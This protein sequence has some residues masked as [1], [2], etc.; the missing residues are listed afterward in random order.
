MYLNIT[1]IIGNTPLIKMDL[2]GLDKINFYAKLEYY[3][4][5]GSVKD[6]AADYILKKLVNDSIIDQD[7]TIIESSSGNF[8]ISL[9]VFCKMHNLKFYC[10][11][12][13]NI[14]SVNEMLISSLSTRI[15]KVTEPDCYG[16]YLCNRLLKV[17]EL[18]NTIP[19]TY[20]INQYGNPYNAEAYYKT[21]GSELCN[22]VNNIDYIFVGVSSG[23]TIT[24]VSH[25]IKERFPKAKVIAVDSIGS[26]IFGQQPKKRNIPGIGSSIRP[27]IIKS[28]LIDDV[29]FIDEKEAVEMCHMLL[30]RHSIFVG[31]SSGSVYA[32]VIKYFKNRD[33]KF[34]TN[35]FAVFPDRGD[36]Y[37]STIYNNDWCIKHF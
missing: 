31:G 19:N 35:V 24:G 17:K 23:G 4:P 12:D 9:S 6:R 11:V 37:S 1:D 27:E 26:V 32:A 25:R 15:L 5:T 10:V 33:I 36:R 7:T 21:L 8:G 3:N 20:W 18:I 16:G 13:P 29:V 22:E 2:E 34:N 28:A 14:T 30:S